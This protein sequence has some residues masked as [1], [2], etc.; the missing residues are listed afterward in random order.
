MEFKKSAL[1]TQFPLNVPKKFR[2]KMW[3]QVPV[4]VILELVLLGMFAA[5]L[6]A[7]SF[8]GNYPWITLVVT[9]LLVLGLTI[10]LYAWYVKAYIRTY[11]YSAD[12][13][14]ITI[15]KGVF[16]PVEIHV[17]YQKIQDVYVDQ[18]LLD[19][20]MG[21]YDVHIASA[22]VSS[23]IEAHIDG[24]TKENA[25]GLKEFLLHSIKSGSSAMNSASPTER[26]ASAPATAVKFSAKEEIS[27][28]TY[29]LNPTWFGLNMAA[30]IIWSMV[31][32]IFVIFYAFSKTDVSGGTVSTVTLWYLVLAVVWNIVS[33]VLWKKNYAFKFNEDFI[34]YKEGII[35]IN[36]KHMPYSSVQDVNVSQSFF[37]RIFGF[38]KVAIQDATQAPMAVRGRGMPMGGAGVTLQGLKL[39]NAQKISDELRAVILTKGNRGANGL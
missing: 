17:Q 38:A 13:N 18:D 14:F 16:M 27:N 1:Q 30:R 25:E 12:E 19:R 22:T 3:S 4:M 24:V 39:V 6:L 32:G 33:L 5:F 37:E 2:K 10:G 35:T 23:G 36:E 29:P 34:Y 11:Y 15:K 7:F 21:L 28:T 31:L 20:I 9:S 26:S 8:D